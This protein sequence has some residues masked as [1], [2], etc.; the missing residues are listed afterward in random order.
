M[1]L[2][3]RGHDCRWVETIQDIDEN[4]RAAAGG[5]AEGDRSRQ[6]VV[7]TFARDY[8]R[9]IMHKLTKL[10]KMSLLSYG[11]A[12]QRLA[13]TGHKTKVDS[14][15]FWIHKALLLALATVYRLKLLAETFFLIHHRT[16]VACQHF[17]QQHHLC[18]A[19]P[20]HHGMP[21]ANLQPWHDW[22]RQTCI[23]LAST[24][25]IAQSSTWTKQSQPVLALR[26]SSSRY[27][28]S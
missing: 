5:E 8:I 14:S 19:E 16:S 24:W 12:V 1:L 18:F 2:D 4:Q 26:S 7:C 28:P 9:Q 25:C 23:N 17:A 11:G 15:A 3:G 13:I 10:R 27:T 22:K 21:D 6:G 20:S